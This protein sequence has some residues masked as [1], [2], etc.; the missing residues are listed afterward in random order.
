M[1]DTVAT[2]MGLNADDLVKIIGAIGAAVTMVLGGYAK[3]VIAKLRG[4]RRRSFQK[5]RR[6]EN[7][8]EEIAKQGPR[9]EVVQHLVNEMKMDQRD[10]SDKK[11]ASHEPHSEEA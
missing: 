11:D 7:L 10:S 8:V 3:V 4:A 9:S 5:I 2:M 1:L 6:L